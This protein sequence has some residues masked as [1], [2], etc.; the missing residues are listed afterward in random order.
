MM[1]SN[2]DAASESPASS[3]PRHGIREIQDQDQ[4]QDQDQDHGIHEIQATETT[5]SP[6]AAA[7][8]TSEI[9]AP[10]NRENLLGVIPQVYPPLQDQDQDQDQDREVGRRNNE[11]MI[12]ENEEDEVEGIQ[13]EVAAR[14]R[15]LN[16]EP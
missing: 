7:Q 16:L 3:Q 9:P 6:A 2:A 11:R 14:G 15:I 4:N 1:T 8:T 13:L 10:G 12:Q 5:D